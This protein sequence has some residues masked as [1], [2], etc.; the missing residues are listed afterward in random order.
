LT[1]CKRKVEEQET[2]LKEIENSHENILITLKS[3]QAEIDKLE[4][5]LQ[6]KTEEEEKQQLEMQNT[7][8]KVAN[9]EADLT[10]L[11][12]LSKNSFNCFSK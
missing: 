5:E 4:K 9:L 3:K 1:N 6:A 2:H 7:Q 11:E 12:I 10:E 8:A